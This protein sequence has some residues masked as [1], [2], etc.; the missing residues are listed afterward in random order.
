MT[1]I[2][3]Q[4]V[5][6]DLV[7]DDDLE[8][9]AQVERIIAVVRVAVVISVGLWL[10]LHPGVATYPVLAWVAVVVAVAYSVAVVLGRRW[11]YDT[12][13]GSWTLTSCDAALTLAVVAATGAGRSPAVAILFLVVIT[14]AM[15]FDIRRALVLSFVDSAA[16]AA[17][18]VFASRP[19]LSTG[20][21]VEAA[22]WW[23]FYLVSA[24]LLTGVLSRL[25]EVEHRLRLRADS[26]AQLAR[27]RTTHLEALER[28]REQTVRV[29][30]HE[31]RTPIASLRAL[32][33]QL[34][35][36]GGAADTVTP[37]QER[38]TRLIQEHADHLADMCEAMREAING[39]GLEAFDRGVPCDVPVAV[40]ID[41]AVAA[42]D[43]GASVEVRLDPPDAIVTLDP[44]RM[45]RVVT[46]LV[47]NAVR[48]NP[49]DGPPVLVEGRIRDG[50]LV[51]RVAD[52]GPGISE[53]E[54]ELV[55]GKGIQFG[56]SSGSQGLG[57]WMVDRLVGNMGGTLE[58]LSKPDQGFQAVV[59]LPVLRPYALGVTVD[60]P[61]TG[62]HDGAGT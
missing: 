11:F 54:V 47:E 39:E 23:S 59:T 49:A 5:L 8:R 32:S 37:A 29:V 46:N 14:A 52:H 57:L 28:E 53:E 7:T 62:V 9:L 43:Q 3:S 42:A 27:Q 18:A 50:Y 19:E 41:A 40:V 60:G 6:A 56:A 20:D 58:M 21:R 45:R 4:P 34:A 48:H 25:A 24:A 1:R 33:R 15:R 35:V 26:A 10:G 36:S 51:I 2:T 30:V 31:F 55:R 38:A 13:R 22:L 16:Y 12:P 17:V 44:A 61:P